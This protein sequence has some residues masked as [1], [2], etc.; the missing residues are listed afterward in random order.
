MQR[1]A[2]GGGDDIGG[3]A[4]ARRLGNFDHLRGAE[5]LGD[6]RDRFAAP[7]ANRLAWK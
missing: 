3:G 2:F 4:G 7:P 5:R 1:R 6:A